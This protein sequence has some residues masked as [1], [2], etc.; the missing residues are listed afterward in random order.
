MY[1]VYVERTAEHDLRQLSVS[2]FQRIISHIK[3]LAKNPRPA[4]CRK[5]SGSTGNDWRVRVG[6]Y[7]I[8]YE[9]A[10]TEKSIRV[11]RVKHRS[12]AYR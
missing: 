5:I 2:N 6:D 8:I 12:Q 11:M 4:G 1:E 9:I 7:R 10:D 3:A